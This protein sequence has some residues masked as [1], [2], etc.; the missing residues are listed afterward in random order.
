MKT[1]IAL[2]RGINVSGKNS[3]KMD[4]LRL[5]LEKLYFQQVT[6]YIQSGNIVFKTENEN[7]QEIELQ[8]AQQ[9]KM[10]FGYDIPVLVL[11]KEQ[12]EQIIANNPFTQQEKESVFLHVTFFSSSPKN[13]DR[14]TIEVK[15]QNGEE[16]VIAETAIYLFC[17]KGY[18]KTK[19]TNNFLET[20]LKINCTTRNWKTINELFKMMKEIDG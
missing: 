10:D 13:F 2:L 5:S 11:E 3:I 17:P 6:T 8:I 19:L 9:I 20:A 18:G 1:Y 12:L 14:T 7:T 15:K 16:I 4:V